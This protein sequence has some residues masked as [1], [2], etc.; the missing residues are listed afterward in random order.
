MKIAIPVKDNILEIFPKTGKAP[1]FAI[2]N[3]SNFSHLVKNLVE[4]EAEDQNSTH[5]DHIAFHKKQI[6]Q[7]GDI[8]AVLVVLIGKHLRKAF[9]EK[10]IQI[11]EFPQNDFK[12]AIDLLQAYLKSK[13]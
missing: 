10:N 4:E 5:E 1:Y 7:L 6:E 11:I 12:N 13:K 8:E 2:F 3:D 9:E